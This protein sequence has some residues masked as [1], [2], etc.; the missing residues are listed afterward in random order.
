MEIVIGFPNIY[1]LDSD[2]SS[3]Q[4]YPILEQPGPGVEFFRDFEN[5]LL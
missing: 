3:G 1:L 2:L 4:H 5:E